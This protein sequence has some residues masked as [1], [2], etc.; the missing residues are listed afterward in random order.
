MTRTDE[1]TGKLLDGSLTDGEWAELDGLLSADP[2]AEAEHLALLDLEAVLRGLR[3]DFD[4]AEPTLAKVREVQAENTARA[5]LSEIAT[6]PAPH[7]AAPAT[8][9]PSRRRFVAAAA[10]VACAA[11]LAV[12]VWLGNGTPS[13]PPTGEPP[14]APAPEFA[15]L[16]HSYGDVEIVTPAGEVFPAAEGREIGPGHTLRTVGEDSLARVE[17]PDR[18]TVDIEPDSVVRFVSVRGGTAVEPRVFLAAGQLTAA[19]PDGYAGRSL[20]VGTGV[21]DVFSRAGTFVVASAGP[22]SARV[23]VRDGNVDV[24]RTDAPLPV[25]VTGGAF[26][27]AGWADVFTE[28]GL[29]TDRTPRRR[30]EFTGARDAVF[31]PDGNVWVASGKQFTLW[32]RDGGTADTVFAPRKGNDGLAAAFTTDLTTLV[33]FVGPNKDDRVNVRG[34]PEADVRTALPFQLP[35]RRFWTVAPSA[36]WFALADPKQNNKRVR[37]LD[38]ATGGERFAREF[39]DSV[40]TVAASPDGKVLAVGVSD[41]GRGTH[42][43]IVLFDAA[44]GDRL[45]TLPSQKKAVYALAFSADGRHLAAGFNGTIQV[46]DVA[47]RELVRAI[48]GFERVVHCLAFSPEGGVLSAGTQDGQVWVWSAASGKASQ[49]I[50][51]G[52]RGVRSIAFDRDGKRLVTVAHDAP[53]GVWDVAEIP[54]EVQ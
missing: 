46:W 32:T 31:A 36:A 24:V 14:A 51:V 3:T 17:L 28:N 21:A 19:V 35:E 53:V 52:R 7:W 16:V 20:V 1:L 45:A 54:A 8:P 47:A 41:L 34:L 10:L 30:L 40:G 6:R 33:T 25:A 39:E 37:V 49:L 9:A 18:T 44:T 38:G 4:L 22:E 48:T 12:G 42:N 29:R 27:H 13:P 15:R 26:I 23:D 43:K 5:V 11:V 50:E 2:A